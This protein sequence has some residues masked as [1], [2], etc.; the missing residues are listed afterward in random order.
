MQHLL[1]RLAQCD[2]A[3]VRPERLALDDEA[4]VEQDVERTV[5]AFSGYD[6]SV[7]INSPAYFPDSTTQRLG[8]Q[9]ESVEATI[10]QLL[11]AEFVVGAVY[12]V[13]KS[14]LRNTYLEIPT[15]LKP[16]AD[17]KDEATLHELSLFSNWNS[18]TGL[19]G[20]VEGNW[21]SQQL[22]DDPRGLAPGALPR[23]GDD[24]WQFN[25]LLGYRFNRNHAE[26]SLGVL[27]IND[28]DYRLSP[29]SPYGDIPRE[30][31]AVVRCRF[32]F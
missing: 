24:F 30:R 27:N 28:A 32:T 13:T 18:P 16:G 19:F 6:S 17:T 2:R 8:Y 12:R 11:G 4:V 20:R 31:T 10:N 25:A 21:Y 26:I 1:G 29:L 22:E 5:G 7:F 15:S 3:V 23:N 9:E 14:E